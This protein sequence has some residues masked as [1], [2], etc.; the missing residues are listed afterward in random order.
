MYS[1]GN[2]R[3]SVLCK[4]VNALAAIIIVLSVLTRLGMRVLTTCITPIIEG[5]FF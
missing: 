3:Y 2:I 4:N 5:F 1:E